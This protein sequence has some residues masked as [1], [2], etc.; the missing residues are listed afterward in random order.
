ME[1][2]SSSAGGGA[3]A[4]GPRGPLDPG[5]TIG[6]YVV[7]GTIARGGIG[8]VLRAKDPRLGRG[9]AIK[10]VDDPDGDELEGL[11]LG[12]AR[13]LA[14]LS[15]PNIVPVYD[16]GLLEDGRVW[17]AMELIDGRTI[18]EWSRGQPLRRIV[19]AWI[20]VGRAV[21][22]AHHASVLHRDIKPGN[23]MVD[24][25]DRVRVLDFGLTRD[26]STAR[27][28]V[29]K[30]ARQFFGGVGA[31]PA[32]SV[33]GT[34]DYMAPE[35]FK[36]ARVSPSTD[37]FSFC[38]SMFRAV[39]SED[40]FAGAARGRWVERPPEAP[41]PSQR[42]DTSE[43]LLE[44]VLLRGLD[45][46]PAKRW[47]SMD[48]LVAA[49]C[50]AFSEATRQASEPPMDPFEPAQARVRLGVVLVAL[51]IALIIAS[52]AFLGVTPG[53]LVLASALTLTV[54]TGASYRWRSE[55]FRTPF[56]K[57]LTTMANL[58]VA[59][60]LVHRLV[61]LIDAV[62]PEVTL[63]GDALVVAAGSAYIGLTW[64]R[65][66]FIS[67]VTSVAAACACALAPKGAALWFGASQLVAVALY[68]FRALRAVSTHADPPARP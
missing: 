39:F 1:E 64:D 48:A 21:A 56:T 38:V 41:K 68:A 54:L 8:V 51:S 52:R 29:G 32:G 14:K 25:N 3:G 16:V 46:D 33:V 12:E 60:A 20:D 43:A 40:P 5:A 44:S 62:A 2:T 50:T 63:R 57:M 11:L 49:L 24:R 9:V 61:N 6:P 55:L 59:T 7:E 66:F 13:S 31:T 4:D 53:V 17:V 45:P 15:H 10:V 36:G 26:S 67:T 58:V 37:Q 19:A 65:L 18:D 34:M 35:L 23:V 42:P 27:L 30:L 47:P 22:H 28:Q